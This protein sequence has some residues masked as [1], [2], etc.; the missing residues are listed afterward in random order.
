MLGERTMVDRGMF[1]AG[2]G[3]SELRAGADYKFYIESFGFAGNFNHTAIFRL[4]Q[5]F[6]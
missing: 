5:T 6:R 4:M 1:G 2:Q 3:L